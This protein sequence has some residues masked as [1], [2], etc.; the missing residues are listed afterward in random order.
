ML[1]EAIANLFNGNVPLATV[2]MSLIPLIELKGGIVFAWESLG[3]IKSFLLAYVGSTI[4]FIPVFFL[5]RPI[6]NL[7]KKW[8]AF[9]GFA[10]KV[11]GYFQGKADETEKNQTK[12]SKNK[13]SENSLKRLGVFLFV[14]I[15]LPMTGVWT[16]TAIAVFL[17]LN[18]KEAILPIVIGNFIA[19]LLICGLSSICSLIG[20][21]LNLV[22]CCLLALAVI[23]LFIT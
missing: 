12:N 7:L 13:L 15:P 20:I 8:K 22:L 17:N 19:G 14:A 3:F 5:L 21:S 2:F 11:E 16:G 10:L 1:T 6:L 4:V 9:N 23:L 18:F